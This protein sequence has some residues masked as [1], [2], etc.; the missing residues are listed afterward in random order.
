MKSPVTPPAPQGGPDVLFQAK[1]QPGQSQDFTFTAPA[2]A[3]EYQVICDVPGHMEANMVGK[4]TV[5]QP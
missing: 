2:T 4:M 3:G 5:T 1:V